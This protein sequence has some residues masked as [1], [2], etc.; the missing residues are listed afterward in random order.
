MEGLIVLPPA[1][2][3]LVATAAEGQAV[4][5]GVVEDTFLGVIVLLRFRVG[6][7]VSVRPARKNDSDLQLLVGDEPGQD[8]KAGRLR[9]LDL[10][11]PSVES[12]QHGPLDP[13]LE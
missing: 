8:L 5:V 4:A 2:P 1:P 6:D 3:G 12:A 11:F 7:R 13:A 9:A 10:F